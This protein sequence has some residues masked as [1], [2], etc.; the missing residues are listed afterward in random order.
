MGNPSDLDKNAPVEDTELDF[1]FS[2]SNEDKCSTTKTE[3]LSAEAPDASKDFIQTEV[4]KFSA[5]FSQAKADRLKNFRAIESGVKEMI[6][7]ENEFI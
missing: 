3:D 6:K 2:H 5:Q 1:S 4:F 7:S